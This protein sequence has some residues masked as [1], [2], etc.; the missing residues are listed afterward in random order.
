MSSALFYWRAI[1]LSSYAGPAL[2]PQAEPG[3]FRAEDLYELVPQDM[4]ELPY[5]KYL[6]SKCPGEGWWLVTGVFNA[7]TFSSRR[8]H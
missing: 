4:G 6:L 8:G 7:P 5:N 2:L 1:E 3:G